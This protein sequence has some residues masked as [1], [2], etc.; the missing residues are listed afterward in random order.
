MNAAIDAAIAVDLLLLCSAWAVWLLRGYGRQVDRPRRK[1]LS[2]RG[3]VLWWDRELAGGRLARADYKGREYV[4][5][6]TADGWVAQTFGVGQFTS[7]VVCR[8]CDRGDTV[9]RLN[10]MITAEALP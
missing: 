7:R 10:A 5:L 8:G 6:P 9:A 1:A 3:A 2:K 4:V